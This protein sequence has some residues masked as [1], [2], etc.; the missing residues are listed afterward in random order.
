[1]KLFGKRKRE[2]ERLNQEVERLRNEHADRVREINELIDNPYSE[3]SIKLKLI[4]NI[5]LQIMRAIWNGEVTGTEA[6]YKGIGTYVKFDPT[7]AI[8]TIEP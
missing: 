6:N 2:V 4:R 8:V 1:M 7:A 3:K 5:D